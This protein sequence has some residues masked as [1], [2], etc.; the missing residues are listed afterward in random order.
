MKV[1]I[2]E[3]NKAKI[4]SALDWIIYILG[5]MSVL[6]L[7]DVMFKSVYIDRGLFGLWAFLATIMI[8]ILN[9]TVKPIIFLLTLPI[10]G[11]TLGLFYP[12]INVFIIK[13]VDFILDVHFETDSIIYLF[14]ISISISIMNFLVEQIVIKPIVRGRKNESNII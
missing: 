11:V 6:M 14:F 4:N 7:A 13:I 5:Y 12:L 8:Y 3:N 10:T 9:K 1:I 2:M